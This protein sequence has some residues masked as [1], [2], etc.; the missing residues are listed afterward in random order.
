MDKKKKPIFKK[1][2]FWL[3]VVLVLLIGVGSGGSESK[4]APAATTA[5]SPAAVETAEPVQ[6]EEASAR[7]NPLD[8]IALSAEEKR[9]AYNEYDK[10]LNEA[11]TSTD[12]ATA[13]GEEAERIENEIAQKIADA[14]GITVDELND[15]YSYAVY[16]YLY[17]ID[18]SSLKATMVDLLDVKITGTTLIVKAKIPSSSTNGQIPLRCYKTVC[19]MICEQGCDVFDE[20]QFWAVADTTAGDETK[21]ISF[22]VPGDVIKVVAENDPAMFVKTLGDYTEDLWM[23]PSIK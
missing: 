7:E 18:P 2:W 15:I 12:L 22:T 1:W 8:Y 3:L 21:V 4:D 16:G 10:A 11:Y 20:I 6:A 19:D 5:S 9:A 13:P 23:L 14:H 17:D